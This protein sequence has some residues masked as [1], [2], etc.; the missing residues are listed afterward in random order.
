VD[1]PNAYIMRTRSGTTTRMT[2]FVGLMN[3][4]ECDSD[5]FILKIE[6]RFIMH[7]AAEAAANIEK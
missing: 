1:A 4:S 2:C 3:D 7:M 6:R 5:I